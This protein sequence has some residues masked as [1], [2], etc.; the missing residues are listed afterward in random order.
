MAVELSNCLIQELRDPTKATSD[1]LTCVKG[2]FSWG[3]T[4]DEEHHICMGEMTTNDPEES[5]VTALTHQM[6]GF[7]RLLGI[8][9]S[10]LWSCKIQ[11]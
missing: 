7:G 11:W 6:Q 10:V 9:A 5:P 3:Q 4:T 2:N 1:Y 8:H